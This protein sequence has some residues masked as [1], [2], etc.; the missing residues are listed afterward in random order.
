LEGEKSTGVTGRKTLSR[1]KDRAKYFQVARFPKTEF[2]QRPATQLD[3]STRIAR[4][5]T[6]LIISHSNCW[7][8]FN[9]RS[10]N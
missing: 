10:G 5:S 2:S 8:M 7:Q 1:T 9:L 3:L 4:D 6:S